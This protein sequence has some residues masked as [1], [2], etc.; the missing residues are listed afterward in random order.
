MYRVKEQ[1]KLI[2]QWQESAANGIGYWQDAVAMLNGTLDDKEYERR[3]RELLE[4]ELNHQGTSLRAS[5]N[6][7]SNFDRYNDSG[8]F[9]S[10][11]N[12]VTNSFDYITQGV[13]S[14][15]REFRDT[16]LSTFSRYDDTTGIPIQDFTHTEENL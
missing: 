11:N 10:R 13:R 2:T 3:Q 1:T 9:T 8:S 5:E 15:I 6:I 12:F 4:Q 14:Q 16:I 7:L